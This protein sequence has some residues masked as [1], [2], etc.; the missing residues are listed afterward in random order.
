VGRLKGRHRRPSKTSKAISITSTAAATGAFAA[1][2]ATS[3]TGA[4][5]IIHA[6]LTSSV[7][8]T[9]SGT[10]S[11]GPAIVTVNHGDTLSSIAQ[12]NCNNAD[13]WTGLYLSNKNKIGDDPNMIEPGTQLT[14][15][16]YQGTVNVAPVE[17]AWDHW[18][19][20]NHLNH[21]RLE[22]VPAPA[23]E[24]DAPQNAPVQEAAEQPSNST[25]NPSDYSGYQACVIK[26]ESGGDS[27]IVNPSS[28]AGGL[29][30][31]L[32]ST[33]A[34]LGYSGLPQDA[35]VSEQTQAFE[36]L[37][38]EAGSSPWVSDGC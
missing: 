30:Q 33:W 32:P 16:C 5:P 3:S 12:D 17:T 1:V 10:P 11:Q 7:V 21:I 38:A 23:P 6:T 35:P 13:D 14:L 8:R 26:R 25:V 18:N 34:S 29:Y 31:F 4:Q 9:T 24:Q 15:D 36:K 37:Y 27:T 28:G 2:A 19:H 22:S 20:I